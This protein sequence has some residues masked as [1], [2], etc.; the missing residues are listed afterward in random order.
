MVGSSRHGR[1]VLLVT[2]CGERRSRPELGRSGGDRMLRRRRS[3]DA[4]TAA[5][6]AEAPQA[7]MQPQAERR[8][9]ARG[10]GAA[11]PRRRLRPRPGRV[12]RPPKCWPWPRPSGGSNPPAGGAQHLRRAGSPRR[13]PGLLAQAVCRRRH[14]G[15]MMQGQGRRRAGRS[16]RMAGGGRMPGDGPGMAGMNPGDMMAR[17]QGQMQQR[18]GSN[19]CRADEPANGTDAAMAACLVGRARPAGGPGGA[20]GSTADKVRPISG[21]RKA[22]SGHS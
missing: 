14:D 18:H 13:H 11:P 9:P 17:M 22:P 3:A 4:A 1:G 16:W 12:R 2:G 15:A 20:G 21:R 5:A 19:G 7:P 6:A 10:S 8:R